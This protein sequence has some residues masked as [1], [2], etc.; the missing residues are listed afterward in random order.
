MVELANLTP[1]V[2]IPII[3]T[4]PRPGEKLFEE[5]L[6]AEEGT[7]ATANNRI[8]R[9]RISRHACYPDLMNELVKLEEALDKADPLSVKE[10]LSRL[11][12]NYRPDICAGLSPSCHHRVLQAEAA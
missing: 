11:V 7:T 10:H 5:L 8:H 12:T 1:Y 4:R 6:T 9:A 3:T 2:D